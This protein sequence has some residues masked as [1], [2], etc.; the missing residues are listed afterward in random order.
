MFRS[1]AF[2]VIH[3]ELMEGQTLN[4]C[5]LFLWLLYLSMEK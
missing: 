5:I 2:D 4:V 3:P 1:H